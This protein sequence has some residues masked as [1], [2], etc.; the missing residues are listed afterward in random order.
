MSFQ[1]A[2]QNQRF[3]SLQPRLRSLRV[4]SI[5][6]L[7]SCTSVRTRE[8]AYTFQKRKVNTPKLTRRDEGL[9]VWSGMY[10][11]AVWDDRA[12]RLLAG[13][14]LDGKHIALTYQLGT[15]AQTERAG[16]FSSR[17]IPMHPLL[18]CLFFAFPFASTPSVCL[19]LALLRLAI[20]L[21]LFPSLP[22]SSII[23]P[24]SSA[25]ARR[26]SP[27]PAPAAG[28]LAVTLLNERIA[29]SYRR[30]RIWKE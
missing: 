24:R 9:G 1:L 27:T 4:N 14:Y 7:S 25:T 19:P 15:L 20:S 18:G 26:R 23:L 30:E 5:K 29:S 28:C 8:R 13:Q 21:L 12:K 11:L 2:P 17:F 6:L 3:C 10:T 16:V 22:R